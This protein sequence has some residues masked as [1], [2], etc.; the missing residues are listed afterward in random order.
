MVSAFFMNN[1]G[2]KASPFNIDI[3]SYAED[4]FSCIDNPR[5]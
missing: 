2:K 5:E 4:Y 1:S 3:A